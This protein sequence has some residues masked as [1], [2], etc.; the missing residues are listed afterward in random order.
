M[1]II[2]EENKKWYILVTMIMASSMV[3]MDTTIL[4]IAIPQMQK[5]LHANMS[6][7]MWIF[8]SYI[9]V[10]AIFLTIG[11]KL[12]DIFGRVKIFY[13][14]IIIFIISSLFCGL[15]CK[16]II[17]LIVFR[18]LQGVSAAIMRPSASTIMNNS[19]KLKERGKAG[20]IYGGLA[21]LSIGIG[22]I[23][24][25][26]LT[27]FISWHWIFFINVPIGILVIVFTIILNPKD[28]I[29]S[30]QKIAFSNFF[31]F[32]MAMFLIIFAVQ[33]ANTF[34]WNIFVFIILIIGLIVFK[35]FLNMERKSKN[36]LIDLEFFKNKN[37]LT[38]F[39]LLF[40][41]QFAIVGENIFGII[42]L[43]NILGISTVVTGILMFLNMI[44]MIIATQIGGAWFDKRGGAYEP[45]CVGMW[46]SFIGFII[47]T[48]A[49]LKIS[50]FFIVISATIISIGMGLT[51][52][53]LFIDLVNSVKTEKRGG[54][55]GFGQM[56]TQ[57]GA[58]FSIA[59]I[60]SLVV[61]LNSNKIVHFFKFSKTKQISIL[62][63]K[64]PDSFNFVLGFL[65][66]FKAESIAGGFLFI[67]VLLAI[68]I[69][70]FYMWYK[71]IEYFE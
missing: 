38:D 61:F 63:K 66:N 54:V 19:F 34:K 15:F 7:I 43:Q 53:R 67:V 24:G 58:T 25:G 18:C 50:F 64:F 42:Y 68:G 14:G 40:I 46:I 70:C 29:L 3:L 1:K 2:K 52:G 28:K 22:P 30:K 4:G 27:Q 35:F 11:G 13:I 6:A 17:L 65:K 9:L 10:Y 71:K 5:D 44:P 32:L 31:I 37:I 41:L 33:E 48:F 62:S 39:V 56:F 8:N 23:I 16:S 51:Y 36:P 26:I 60:T 45:V 21:A 55:T 57:L 47:L 20:A 12:G 59:I 69:I 49:V